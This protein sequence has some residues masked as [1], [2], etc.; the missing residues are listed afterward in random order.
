MVLRLLQLTGSRAGPVKY[1]EGLQLAESAKRKGPRSDCN[2][3]RGGPIGTLSLLHFAG[4]VQVG[5]GG[6]LVRGMQPEVFV[7]RMGC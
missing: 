6:H 4:F 5:G 2:S 3:H 1:G 7:G